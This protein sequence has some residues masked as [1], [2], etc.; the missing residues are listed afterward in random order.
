M[1]TGVWECVCVCV[2]V[3]VFV[4]NKSSFFGTTISTERFDLLHADTSVKARGCHHV[5]SVL[6]TSQASLRLTLDRQTMN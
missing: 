3:F 4:V 5:A 1:T 6:L 2:C